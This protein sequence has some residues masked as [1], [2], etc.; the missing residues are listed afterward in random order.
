[1]ALTTNFMIL[2]NIRFWVTS[3][4]EYYLNVSLHID[5]GVTVLKCVAGGSFELACSSGLTVD[6]QQQVEVSL[7]FRALVFIIRYL[8]H[9]L[10]VSLTYM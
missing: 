10:F 1:M 5:I 7:V 8:F 4:L 9:R 3:K 2:L 6:R